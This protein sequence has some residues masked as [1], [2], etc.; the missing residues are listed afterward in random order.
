MKPDPSPEKQDNLHAW[1]N[2]LYPGIELRNKIDLI[3]RYNNFIKGIT[4]SDQLV[5]N[6]RV[7]FNPVMEYVEQFDIGTPNTPL[8]LNVLRGD[9]TSLDPER[10][11]HLQNRLRELDLI[12]A[13]NEIVSGIIGLTISWSGLP[14]AFRKLGNLDNFITRLE[15]TDQEFSYDKN[16]D[17][18]KATFKVVGIVDNQNVPTG[19]LIFYREG[20][21][22]KRSREVAT[23]QLQ[24]ILPNGIVEA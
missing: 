1:L 13:S 20:L 6:L 12:D 11:V 17:F 19:R 18:V 7:N 2:D 5:G 23:S 8:L 16:Q 24:T 10:T 15:E 3:T 21:S 14:A 22:G 9:R 4:F